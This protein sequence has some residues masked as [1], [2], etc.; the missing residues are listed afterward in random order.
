EFVDETRRLVVAPQASEGIAPHAYHLVVARESDVRP[1]ALDTTRLPH[2][3]C[4]EVQR[5]ERQVV[6]AG[7]EQTADGD[8]VLVLTERLVGVDGVLAAVVPEPLVADAVV[9]DLPVLDR[10]GLRF[11]VAEVPYDALGLVEPDVEGE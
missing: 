2:G 6:R 7:P 3:P 1:I 11:A 4:V 5:V 8:E 10:M 9:G